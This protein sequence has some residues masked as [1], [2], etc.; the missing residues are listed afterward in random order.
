KEVTSN[1]GMLIKDKI[2]ANPDLNFQKE[3]TDSE[4]QDTQAPNS[5]DTQEEEKA[6]TE[7]NEPTK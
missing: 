3:D 6:S 4:D 5:A 2:E 1:F 7:D